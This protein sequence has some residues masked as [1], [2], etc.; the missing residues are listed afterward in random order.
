MSVSFQI[1]SSQ[2]DVAGFKPLIHAL[3]HACNAE[4][5]NFI[6]V[7][8]LARDLIF[9]HQHRITPDR[10]TRDVDVAIGIDD[11]N[12]YNRLST[13][14]T[15]EYGFNTTDR[16]H[17][18]FYRDNVPLDLIPFGAIEGKKREIRWPPE[19]AFVMSTIGFSEVYDC[20]LVGV[21]DGELETKVASLPG[22][23]I[24]KLFAWNDRSHITKKDAKDFCSIVFN[25]ID[26]IGMS[27]YD[28]HDD[29]VND[30]FDRPVASAQILGRDSQP[31]LRLSTDLQERIRT[32]LEEET[33]DLYT[34][35]LAR[36][37]GRKCIYGIDKRFRCLQAYLT[38][39]EENIR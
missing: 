8:A 17:R 21:I 13:R 27:L 20:S 4:G 5:I 25:Y 30:D 37:M 22:I 3:H 26:I 35:Q 6:V 9:E 14:L 16:A 23:G 12:E 1:D 32:L 28:D 38:G 2:V 18:L 10:A 15:E 29:L 39:T 24:L 11:W 34:S 7:G 33:S 36:D 31:I 19:E